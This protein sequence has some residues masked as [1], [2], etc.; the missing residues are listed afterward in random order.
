[1]GSSKDGRP[2]RRHHVDLL[3]QVHLRFRHGFAGFACLDLFHEDSM[4]DLKVLASKRLYILPIQ[5]LIG[6]SSLCSG[7]LRLHAK[8]P[9]HV[10]IMIE[11]HAFRSGAE[12][13]PPFY[14][15]E[16]T[17]QWYLAIAFSIRES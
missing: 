7:Q 15:S 8:L 13:S 12:A 9:D 4:S 11:T 2:R 16:R 6:M 1:M 5:F 14:Y 10:A 3:Q 17:I